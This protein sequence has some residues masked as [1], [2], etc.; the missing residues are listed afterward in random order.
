M[1]RIRFFRTGKKHQPS[2]KIVVTNKKNPPQGGRFVDEVGFWSPLTKERKI[3][4]EKVQ[5][6][7]SK[8][9]KP[10]DSVYNLLVKEK[11][12]EGEK[13]DVRKKSKKKKEG[14][15][16]KEEKKEEKEA[17]VEAGSAA[18]E[19]EKKEEAA[20]EG[21]E[22][23]TNPPDSNSESELKNTES[24]TNSNPNIENK[25]EENKTD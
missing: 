21:E 16:E 9:A 20:G 13:I 23:K 4:T 12:L 8:G 3:K 17:R 22:E 5:Y 7:L 2:F 14:S 10:S 1:L 19:T 25:T 24:N 6:W 18:A 11:V 15:G